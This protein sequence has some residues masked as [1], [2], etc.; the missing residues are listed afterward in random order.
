MSKATISG[1]LSNCSTTEQLKPAK[2]TSNP[3]GAGRPKGSGKRRERSHKSDRSY[4]HLL[5]L[6]L[7]HRPGL[8]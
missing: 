8:T 5:E 7:G 6:S 2:T 1:D 3:K 4:D